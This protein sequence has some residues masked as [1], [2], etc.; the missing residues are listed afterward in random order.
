MGE[1]ESGRGG[2][3]L[4]MDKKWTWTGNRGRR[5]PQPK[6]LKIGRD[7]RRGREVTIAILQVKR[8]LREFE[9]R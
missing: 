1:G 2:R 4:H 3:L 9:R 5:R 7:W 6:G 8:G